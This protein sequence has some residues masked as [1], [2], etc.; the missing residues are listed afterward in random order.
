MLHV[1]PSQTPHL[2][3]NLLSVA[4]F[5]AACMSAA[6]VPAAAA[7]E[8]AYEVTA[9][10]NFP[11]FNGMVNITDVNIPLTTKTPAQCSSRVLFNIRR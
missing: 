10:D 7:L 5:V 6:A 3:K 9:S 11:C 2:S 1:H 8:P 4:A